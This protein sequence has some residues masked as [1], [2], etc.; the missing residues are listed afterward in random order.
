V[1]T[2][3]AVLG[4]LGIGWIIQRNFKIM[5]AIDDLKAAVTR[6]NDSTSAELK[7]ISDKLSQPNSTDAD[8]E[9]AATALNALSDKLDAETAV[10]TATAP[11]V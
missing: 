2:P 6:L 5:A 7:A 3:L 1:Y 4:L 11:T 8:V 10:L 9:A